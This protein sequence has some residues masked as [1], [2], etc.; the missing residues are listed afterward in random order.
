MMEKSKRRKREED[1]DTVFSFGGKVWD[2]HR[3]ESTLVRTKKSTATIDLTSKFS[4]ERHSY[5][6]RKHPCIRG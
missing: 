6:F 3:A 5:G 1:K 4:H 2:S